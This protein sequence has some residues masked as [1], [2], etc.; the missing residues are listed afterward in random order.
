MVGSIRRGKEAMRDKKHNTEE[1]GNKEGR[2]ED[3]MGG[4]KGEEGG[5]DGND[6]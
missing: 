3:G 1:K 2:P 5:S 4:R 6:L